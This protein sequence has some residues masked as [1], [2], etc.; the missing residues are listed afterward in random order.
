MET[1]RM[2]LFLSALAVGFVWNIWEYKRMYRK[3]IAIIQQSL[4]ELK[5]LE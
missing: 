1:W 2:T 5:G 3:N 4:E